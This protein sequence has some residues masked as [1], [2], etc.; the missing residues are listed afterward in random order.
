MCI[1][2][3]NMHV[4]IYIYIYTCIPELDIPYF[5]AKPIQILSKQ[6]PGTYT[7]TH[8]PPCP[9]VAVDHPA[10]VSTASTKGLAELD[11]QHSQ[12][13]TLW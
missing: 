7:P 11:P 9:P 1:Y 6:L 8:L 5:M 12:L 4:Y 3:Y 2:V 10:E 13:R